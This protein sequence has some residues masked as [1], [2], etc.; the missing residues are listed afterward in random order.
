M[1]K[2]IGH[3]NNNAILV[4]VTLCPWC[5]NNG[6]LNCVIEL[7]ILF[8]GVVVSTFVVDYCIGN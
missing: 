7:Q 8:Q 5:K 2:D 1:L 3:N 4:Y 6:L